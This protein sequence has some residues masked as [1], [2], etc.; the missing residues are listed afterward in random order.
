LSK[1][2]ADNLPLVSL[3]IQVLFGSGLLFLLLRAWQRH[4]ARYPL[5]LRLLPDQRW[6]AELSGGAEVLN[7]TDTAVTH[8]SIRLSCSD[9]LTR[10][11]LHARQQF[12]ALQPSDGG[13][14][15]EA[16]LP[17]LPPQSRCTLLVARQGTGDLDAEATCDQG[18]AR[19]AQDNP[20]LA[21]LLVGLLIVMCL[22]AT[23]SS[24]RLAFAT[25]RFLRAVKGLE[26]GVKSAEETRSQVERATAENLDVLGRL[27]TIMK[28]VETQ[29]RD[30][31]SGPEVQPI[32]GPLLPGSSPPRR[33]EGAGSLEKGRRQPGGAPLKPPGP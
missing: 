30:T 29:T 11:E 8:V 32:P 4:R 2:V 1:W 25:T 15:V 31:S 20:W 6:Q 23:V 24:V 28:E 13:R 26:E 5:L 16:N 21:R 17:R 3:I 19:R 33:P 18:I 7:T 9:P 12:T 27:R 22:A 14:V 10:T